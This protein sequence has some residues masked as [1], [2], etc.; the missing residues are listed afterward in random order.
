MLAL[1]H[2]DEDHIDGIEECFEL[3]C[4]NKYCEGD[5]IKFKEL[6]LPACAVTE[7]NLTGT[8]KIIRDEA[9]YR[10]KNGLGIK[11]FQQPKNLKNG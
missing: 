5:R 10:L 9:R 4:H 8:A 6:W 11:V 3:L 2:I 7:Q 1:T